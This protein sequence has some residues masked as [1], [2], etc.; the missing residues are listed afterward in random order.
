MD[1]FAGKSL[2]EI[3]AAKAKERK[4]QP[5]PRAEKA[6]PVMRREK[7]EVRGRGAAGARPFES[8][9]V[10][11]ER[12]EHAEPRGSL[13]K[14]FIGTFTSDGELGRIMMITRQDADPSTVA[15][16]ATS[17]GECFTKIYFCVIYALQSPTRISAAYLPRTSFA[18]RRWRW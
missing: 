4:P 5:K 2:D 3:I 7:P 17:F 18:S 13:R 8:K 15:P 14:L 11:T 6:K 10:V 16:S 12:R 9:P 1:A